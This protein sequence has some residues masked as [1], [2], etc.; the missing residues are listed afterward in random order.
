VS[1]NRN[2]SPLER[3]LSARSLIGSLLLRS[4]PPRMRG[5]R[6]V[7]WCELFGVSE[8]AARVA[9]SRMVERGELRAADGTYELAGRVGRR[10]PAQDWSL[11]PRL[12]R[13]DGQ[14]RLAT[15]S[16]RGRTAATRGALR[17][18]MRR[19][20]FGEVREGVW[21]RPHNLPRAA[22]PAD[23]WEVADAQCAWW[24]SVPE[25]DPAA[26]VVTLF[27]PGGWAA[28]AERLRTR[29]DR[30]A[31]GLE[32][33]HDRRLAEAFETGVA[34]LAHIRADPLLPAELGPSSAAG[35]ALRAVYTRY[36]VKFSSA[37]RAWFR[38]QT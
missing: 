36:E 28:R 23:A 16:D 34:A 37:L 7:Q 3:P 32:R 19:L 27:D 29:L 17:G 10:R 30:V 20:R 26:L 1:A 2:T 4:E 14:W 38:A 13:W 5:A 33:A 31:A 35:A 9:L 11:R 24:T 12:Q 15:V 18:A 8:G 22:A 6:L 21:T 25:H